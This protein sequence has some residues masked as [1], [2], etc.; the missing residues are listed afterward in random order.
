M[1]Q[2]ARQVLNVFMMVVAIS[3]AGLNGYA[4]ALAACPMHDHGSGTH[5][6]Q[7]ASWTADASHD[8][9]A[10]HG[11]GHGA[12]DVAIG[13]DGPSAPPGEGSCNHVH[14]HCC[15]TFAVEP[16]ECGLKVAADTRASVPFADAHIPLGQLSSPLFRPPCAVA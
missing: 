10:Q 6:H 1:R 8:G 16:A 3:V 13:D 7:A 5:D 11:D 2:L 15:A 12:G 4:S 9:D 14:L